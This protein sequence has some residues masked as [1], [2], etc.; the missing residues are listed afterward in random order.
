MWI[1]K[2]ESKETRYSEYLIY[3]IGKQLLNFDM[4]V[5][6]LTEDGV[7]S[8]DFTENNVYNFEPFYSFVGDNE[9]YSNSFNMLNTISPKLA[10]DYLKMLYLDTLYRNY[11]RHNF[12]FGIL[13]DADNG[14][15]IKLAPNFDNNTALIFN[16]YLDVNKGVAF[17]DLFF[18]LLNNNKIAREMFLKINIPEITEKSLKIL[19]ISLIWILI[20]N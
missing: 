6:E 16:S 10:I 13:C 20:K 9:D 11:D 14:N 3:L 7:R 1:Y 2:K 19:M 5:Y 8:K 4:V 12:N 15:V 17:D 18:N